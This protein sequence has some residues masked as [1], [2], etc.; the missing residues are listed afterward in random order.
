MMSTE[1]NGIAD[2]PIP[3]CDAFRK[4]W[5]YGD[6]SWT[7]FSFQIH[8]QVRVSVHDFDSTRIV[9][10]RAMSR[11]PAAHTID[12]DDPK[13]PDGVP[14][15]FDTDRY[16]FALLAYRLLVSKTLDSRIDPTRIPEQ[17]APFEAGVSRRLRSLWVRAD[18]ARGTRPTVLECIHALE[19]A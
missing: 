16:R 6:I 5:A 2:G 7:N 9:G 1:P 3:R 12:W 11:A 19:S 10:R 14:A 8:P 4:P 18:G 13:A 15:S 17:F